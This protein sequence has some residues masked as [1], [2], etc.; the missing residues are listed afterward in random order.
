MRAEGAIDLRSSLDAGY[1]LFHDERIGEGFNVLVDMRG[2]SWKPS[3]DEAMDLAT[4]AA[5][6]PRA[7]SRFALLV[8]SCGLGAARIFQDL[9]SAHGFHVELFETTAEAHR[10]LDIEPRRLH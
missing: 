7:A 9:A 8:G 2:S 1:R 4:A 5:H 6:L 10:W 3:S